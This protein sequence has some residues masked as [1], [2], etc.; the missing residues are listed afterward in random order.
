MPDIGPD[1]SLSWRRG[2]GCQYRANFPFEG[3]PWFV[4]HHVLMRSLAKLTM[5]I[6]HAGI[7]G[8]SPYPRPQPA[9]PLVGARSCLAFQNNQH[10]SSNLPICS[11]A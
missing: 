4:H 5:I 9:A 6:Q 1:P 3:I 8:T 7:C 11:P 10:T 2:N